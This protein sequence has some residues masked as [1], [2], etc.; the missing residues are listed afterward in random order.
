MSNAYLQDFV[1]PG[2]FGRGFEVDEGQYVAIVDLEGQQAGDFVA[3][4]R[5]DTTEVL[6]TVHT[7]RRLLS[8]YFKVGDHLLTNLDRPMF[9]VVADTVGIHDFNVPACDPTRYQVDFGVDG[10]RNCLENMHEPLEPYGVDILHVPEPFNLFQ[11]SPVGPDGRV[12]VTDPTNRAGDYV[13]FR[14]TMDVVCA[15]SPCPQDIIPGNG[16]NV[17]DL[18]VVVSDRPPDDLG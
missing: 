3:L 12:V 18:R 14:S 17:T 2:G 15:L 9:D 10:H 8:I 7:R 1:V 11:N 6:S 16:L 5:N 13:V 4:S